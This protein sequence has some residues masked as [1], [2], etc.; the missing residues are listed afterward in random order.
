METT[1]AK[2]EIGDALLKREQ[3][4][5]RKR[6][7]NKTYRTRIKQLSNLA[8]RIPKRPVANQCPKCGKMFGSRPALR[9][10]NIRAH[11]R[12]WSTKKKFSHLNKSRKKSR[13]YRRTTLLNGAAAPPPEIKDAMGDSARAIIMAAQVL[14][15]VNVGMKL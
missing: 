9:M 13:K 6:A 5:A 10:H 1:A 8:H 7:Y 2:Q 11:G 4:L 14:R 15:S 12:G 3:E